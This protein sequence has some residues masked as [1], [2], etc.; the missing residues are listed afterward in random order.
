ME[1]VSSGTILLAFVAILCGL[2]GVFLIR[3]TFKPRPA[4]VA[5]APKRITVPLA[6][7][8]LEAGRTVTIGDV[9]LVRMSNQQ[10]KKQG[11]SGMFMSDP[12]QI[13]GRVVKSPVARGST[14]DTEDFYPDGY[15]PGVSASLKPG[16]RAMTVVIYDK[17]ALIGFAGA[18]QLVDV[19][20]RTGDAYNGYGDRSDVTGHVSHQHWDKRTGFHGG[21]NQRLAN[22]TSGSTAGVESR[23]GRVVTLMQGVT[24]LALGDSV[25]KTQDRSNRSTDESFDHYRV[26]LAVTP[27]QAEV[28]RVVEGQ[29]ELSLT[30]RNP[31]DTSIVPLIDSRT[32][33][34][35]LGIEDTSPQVLE[36]Y[37]GN[38]VQRL[39]F[40]RRGPLSYHVRRH[41]IRDTDDAAMHDHA[42]NPT[43][44]FG[45]GDLTTDHTF[46]PAETQTI[47]SAEPFS[48]TPATHRDSNESSSPLT[49]DLTH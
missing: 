35:I 21:Y 36:T 28:L 46:D 45:H 31:H 1:R 39:T 24:I 16:Q 12:S 6:S 40:D 19:L 7:R 22:R 41:P 26:T 32:L 18:G 20:F 29:G 13:I 17:D 44:T 34:D 10:V 9:A 8:A 15:G 25:V 3:K 33:E 43:S 4:A 42:E 47:N 49:N 5:T 11:I 48:L 2:F 27:A 38:T 14:F 37:R 30:L 23:S